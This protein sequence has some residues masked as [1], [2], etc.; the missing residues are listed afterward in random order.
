MTSMTESFGLRFFFNSFD[1][2]Y[3]VNSLFFIQPRLAG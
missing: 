3:Y 1:L 2:L